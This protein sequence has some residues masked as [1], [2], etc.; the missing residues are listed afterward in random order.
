MPDWE[1]KYDPLKDLID[2]E[3]Y[4]EYEKLKPGTPVSA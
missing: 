2:D 3:V 4:K 1:D